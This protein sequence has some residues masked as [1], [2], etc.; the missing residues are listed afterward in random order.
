MRLDRNRY[1]C[2]RLV[3]DNLQNKN[4]LTSKL[5]VSMFGNVQD[6]EIHLI[7]KILFAYCVFSNNY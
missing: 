1:L 2:T 4:T 5:I 6:L 7:T 3:S